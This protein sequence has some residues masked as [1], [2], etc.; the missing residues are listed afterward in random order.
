MRSAQ[1]TPGGSVDR[2]GITKQRPS[3]NDNAIREEDLDGKRSLYAP[4]TWPWWIAIGCL[5]L[6]TRLPVRLQ[7]VNG[8]VMGRCL[9]WLLP[10]RR[11]I[12]AINLELCFPTL[13]PAS[14]E[15]LLRRHFEGLGLM[16]VET[17]IGCW[18][19]DRRLRGLGR[20]E[21]LEHLNQALAMGRGV[22]L[23]TAHFTALEI[24]GRL[25]SMAVDHDFHGVYRRNENPVL[26]Y[27]IRRGR[28]RRFGKMFGRDDTRGMLKSLKSGHPVWYAPDQAYRGPHSVQ[29]PFFGVSAPS[30][31]GTVRIAKVS[32]APVVPF[33]TLREPDGHYRLRL[34]PALANFPSGDLVAD[35]ARINKLIEDQVRQ[36]PEQ[37]YWVHRR[38]KSRGAAS[39]Y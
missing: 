1:T 24:G 16:V 39:P 10:R 18:V 22:L 19:S 25:L 36:A 9:Y 11:R 29:A 6:H 8:R 15:R 4:R 28:E 17:T 27:C 35:T 26:E 38:F 12:A 3:V 31:P 5:W 21:G 32:G 7:L 30:N 20:V 33:V 13:Q 23:L 34:L 2:N 14:R 37:Y